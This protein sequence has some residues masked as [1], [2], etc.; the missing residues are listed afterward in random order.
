[1][2]D[3]FDVPD[4]ASR[5]RFRPLLLILSGIVLALVINAGAVFAIRHGLSTPL[6][7]VDAPGDQVFERAPG[8]Y[9][10]AQADESTDQPRPTITTDTP[11]AS[12]L[13]SGENEWME[14][15]SKRY[16]VLARLEITEKAPT[17]V[18]LAGEP[19]AFPVM[20]FRDQK[21]WVTTVGMLSVIALAVPVL[22]F[23]TG[24][25]L[26]LRQKN[27]HTQAMFAQMDHVR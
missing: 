5:G 4:A 21:T 14:I 16:H 12:I 6:F 27:R 8:T 11:H 15:Q 25:V 22:L 17:R 1:M 2:P 3:A 18:S 7:T 20:L 23:V 10:W 9:V 19:A 24:I 13:A 26:W